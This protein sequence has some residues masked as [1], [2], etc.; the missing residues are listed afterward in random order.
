MN[1]TLIFP[2]LLYM[3]TDQSNS[4]AIHAEVHVC[5]NSFRAMDFLVELFHN[6]LDHPDW[7]MSRAC[8]DA[9]GKTL[10][11]WHNWLATS[12]FSVMLLVPTIPPLI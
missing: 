5:L 11:K 3:I 1:M 12:S 4:E 2:V 9:Y 10:K 8:T 6:L 7:S